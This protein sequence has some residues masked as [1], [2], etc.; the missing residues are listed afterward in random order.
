MKENVIELVRKS[1]ELYDMS[2]KMYSD[3]IWK[4]KLWGQMG[5]ELKKSR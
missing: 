4:E 5:E 3:N 1:E 2:K